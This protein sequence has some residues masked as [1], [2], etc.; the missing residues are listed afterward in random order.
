RD[1]AFVAQLVEEHLRPTQLAARR[2]LPSHRAVYRF[3]RDLGDAAPACL[4]LTLADAAGASGPRLLPERWRGHVAYMSH[5]LAEGLAQLEK[6]Q[7]RPRLIDGR[8]LMQAL[9]I[10]P[11]PDVGRLLNAI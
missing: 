9:H 10:E 8:D 7:S 11:G 1:T 2:T 4:L 5:V 3:F 6:E